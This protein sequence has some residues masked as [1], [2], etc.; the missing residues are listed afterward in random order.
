LSPVRLSIHPVG[1]PGVDASRPTGAKE[2]GAMG[3][4][5]RGEPT[6]PVLLTVS[7]TPELASWLRERAV[8]NAVPISHQIREEL[9]EHRK[10]CNR[11]RAKRSA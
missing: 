1:W 11:D 8:R 4:K 7:V 3:T 2:G 5:T 6:E 9:E 10:Y